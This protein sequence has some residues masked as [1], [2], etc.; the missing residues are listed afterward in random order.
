MN[1][2]IKICNFADDMEKGLCEFKYYPYDKWNGLLLII[3]SPEDYHQWRMSEKRRELMERN[4]A[5][6]QRREKK[7]SEEELREEM[8]ANG[9]LDPIDEPV[10]SP[11]EIEK[12]LYPDESFP[13][14]LKRKM[15]GGYYCWK[16][17]GVIY[18]LNNLKEKIKRGRL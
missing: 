6:E 8:V 1:L 7:L 10:L 17:H 11:E 3:K 16:E 13:H 2:C 14:K 9:L 18:T 4:T 15:I 5:I 12:L